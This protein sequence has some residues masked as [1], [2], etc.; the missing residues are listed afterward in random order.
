MNPTTATQIAELNRK[1]E[2]LLKE[3]ALLCARII[4]QVAQVERA[5]GLEAVTDDGIL[6]LRSMVGLIRDNRDDLR[7]LDASLRELARA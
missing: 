7:K 3:H 2:A 1:R 4:D 6:R 5:A